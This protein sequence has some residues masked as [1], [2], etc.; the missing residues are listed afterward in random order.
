MDGRGDWHKFSCTCPLYNI[1][2]RAHTNTCKHEHKRS[3]L[4]AMFN[5]SP[6]QPESLVK[7]ESESVASVSFTVRC[8]YSLERG[9]SCTLPML[10]ARSELW[11]ELLKA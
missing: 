5:A 3:K 4:V 2:M 6:S 1:N 8:S 10:S 9:A 7:S 11:L